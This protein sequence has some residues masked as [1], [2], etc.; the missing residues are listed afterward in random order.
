MGDLRR[1][2][3]VCFFICIFAILNPKHRHYMNYKATSVQAAAAHV[4]ARHGVRRV[5]VSPGS[6]D[7]SIIAALD[8]SGEF[9]M[10]RI[11]DER[12]AGF[13]ALGLS[14]VTA[15]PVAL[16][17]TSGTAMLNYAPAVAEAFYRGIPL[18]V[19][20]ADRPVEWIDQD[21]SQTMRQPGALSNVV[22]ASYDINDNGSV[23]SGWA[24]VRILNE[25]MLTALDRRRGPV[26]INI[27]L[28]DCAWQTAGDGS[29]CVPRIIEM[30]SSRRDITYNDASGLAHTL[31]SAKRVM[32]VCTCRQP[33]NNL[34]RAIARLALRCN[35]VVVAERVSNIA[36]R[37][38]VFSPETVISSI[39]E[40]RLASLA[41]ELL[42]TVG[43]APVSGKL[44]E[45]LRRYAPSQH[46]S[47][48]FTHCVV[49]CYRSLT[50]RIEADPAMVL[51]RVASI[52]EPLESEAGY[53]IKWQVASDRMR[54]LTQAYAAKAP[55]SD[56]KAME[57]IASNIPAQWNV[58]LS[59]G[60][61]VR[62]FEFLATGRFHRVDCNR[63]VSGID[64]STSTAVGASLAYSGTTLLIT[65]DMS[66][67]YDLGGMALAGDTRGLKIVVLCNGGGNIFRIIKATRDLKVMEP[68]LS[69]MPPLPLKEL[70]T[71]YGISFY[72]ACDYA[73]LKLEWDKFVVA[74]GPALLAVETDSTVSA[75][76]FADYFKFLKNN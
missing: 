9:Q 58:Q 13:V 50:L 39:E 53:F 2:Y 54:S 51:E 38:V 57:F 11:V 1:F 15:E 19:I 42:I 48:G 72:H 23:D 29:T 45:F 73:G 24:S 7:A 5:V 32:I 28:P 55:W 62:Y 33:D 20:T 34:N 71:A 8:D 43:G 6:R 74:T 52:A 14:A 76:T 46:W 30:L 64:G 63:G 35:V 65:G 69:S 75:S 41:P 70:T 26:H 61:A 40:S 67:A 68:Y 12:C 49:D 66:A 56:F 27:H 37:D 44:K 4:L 59:N 10:T 16:V 18:V 3:P 47:I 25:A 31:A 22:K 17:C 21:D 60:T 36:V